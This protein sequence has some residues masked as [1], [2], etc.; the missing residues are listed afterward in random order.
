MTAEEILGLT[1]K[2]DQQNQQMLNTLEKFNQ[3]GRFVT[4]Q[5]A[6]PP[7]APAQSAWDVG[8]KDDE[9]LTGAQL[10]QALTRLQEA[11]QP[12]FNSSLGIASGTAVRLV[13]DSNKELFAKYGAEIHQTIAQIPPD[14]RTVDNLQLA[15]N[16]IKSTHFE[17]LVA[18]RLKAERERL[19]SD[20]PPTMR[21]NGGAGSGP[22]IPD[23]TMSLQ[24]EGL[25]ADWKAK[26]QRVGLSERQL[27]EFL[28]ANGQSR[29]QFF[30]QFDRGLGVIVEDTG[31]LGVRHG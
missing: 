1:Q 11:A 20:L 29:E 24:A 14:A 6:S 9:Y 28:V 21:P 15:V 8:L 4:N 30:K 16:L 7:P 2:Y 25:P 26:A 27:D 31:K 3:Q 13:A 5:P 22:N 17:E 12:H 23:Q 19:L 18:D 10:R